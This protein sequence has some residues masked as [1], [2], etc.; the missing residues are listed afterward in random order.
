V[1]AENSRKPAQAWGWLLPA[2]MAL[3]LAW[4]CWRAWHDPSLQFLPPGPAPWIVYPSP[5]VTGSLDAQDLPAGFKRQIVLTRKPSK[6]T[7]DWRCFREGQLFINGQIVPIPA[8]ATWKSPARIDVAAQLRAGTNE[9][10]A[11]VLADTGPPAV[12]L[13]LQTD[14]ATMVTDENWEVSLAG[15]LW[16]PA[17]R[18]GTVVEPLAG[19]PLFGAER[20]RPALTRTVGLQF[21]FLA[22]SLLALLI[23][24][25]LRARME[26]GGRREKLARNAA[27]AGLATAW[28]LLLAHNILCL[29]VG[30]GFDEGYHLDYVKYI[31]TTGSLPRANDG[32]EM[33]QA[34]LYYVISAGLLNALHFAAKDM[35][36]VRALRFFNLVIGAADIALVLAGLKMV[37][38][39]HWRKQLAGTALAAFAAW[40]LNL[41]HYTTNEILAAMLGTA[42]LCL[43]LKCLQTEIP[44]VRQ[45]A[46]LGVA[47]GAACLTKASAIVLLPVVFAALAV[48]LIAG[49]KY[50]PKIWVRTVGLVLV[51]ILVVSGWHYARLWIGF[52]S[53][54]AGNWTSGVFSPWWQQPGY[55]TPGYFLSYGRSLTAP[56]YSGYHGFWDAL[57]STLWGDALWGGAPNIGERPPWNYDLMTVGFLLALAPTFFILSGALAALVRFVRQPSPDWLLLLGVPVLFLFAIAFMTLKLPFYGQSKAFY[58]LSALLPISVFAIVGFE[59]W[60][61]HCRP[62]ACVALAVAGAWWLDNYAAFWIRPDAPQTRLLLAVDEYNA[63]QAGAAR[64]LER[65]LESD[66]L[67]RR[68]VEYLARSE[69]AA[70]NTNRYEAVIAK[71]IQDKSLDGDLATLE[72]K[73]LFTIG[74]LADGLELAKNTAHSA[75]DDAGIA[76]TWLKLAYVS[77]QDAEVV[78]AGEWY[79]RDDPRN[80]DAHA[81]V[82]ESLNRM[83]Q[84]NA[85]AMH[86]SIRHASAIQPG[87]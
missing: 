43:A 69:L 15:A 61:A 82:A 50:S 42:S 55:L 19:N 36:G 9:L 41:L 56:F 62:V 37:F 57:H 67:N 25:F 66:P 80:I 87:H 71:A 53:P 72:V 14:E 33:Y 39:G 81:M 63:G 5:Q 51:T 47:L 32:W 84:T 2:L 28:V 85:A 7:L 34:P 26:E 46:A 44:S 40:H 73:R 78:A 65:L 20:M 22:L 68:A 8:A 45:C 35:A 16:S 27:F 64:D 23:W 79:F 75:P 30:L 86:L 24:R 60:T 52:G 76:L 18:A 4:L 54:L 3:G 21:V 29:P 1:Q 48:R 74:R 59:F 12:S 77:Q 13:R 17:A 58:A 31:Q 6:A 70:G 38:P 83:G 49:R 10:V 11:T